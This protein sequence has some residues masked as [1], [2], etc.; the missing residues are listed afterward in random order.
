MVELAV[1]DTGNGISP[2]VL[3]RVFEPF[4][5]TKPVGQGTGMGLAAVHGIVHQRG[6]HL[7][8]ESSKSGTIVR[9]ML[10][11]ASDETASDAKLTTPLAT[12]ETPADT[13]TN[14]GMTILVVD[15]EPALA[16]LLQEL[17]ED[18][19]YRVLVGHS[20]AEA[21]TCLRDPTERVDLVITDLTMPLMS[22]LELAETMLAEFGNLPIIITTGYESGQIQTGGDTNVV[23]VLHK[24]IDIDDLVHQVSDILKGPAN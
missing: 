23:A 22:G 20:G 16:E 7:Q 21:L 24:P 8:L 15:D 5:T 3:P 10:Q 1:S 13:K 9:L 6:G 11:L 14:D 12:E 2:E 19:G 4:F 18:C 17:L